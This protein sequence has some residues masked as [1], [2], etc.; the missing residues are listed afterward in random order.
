MVAFFD[1][2]QDWEDALSQTADFKAEGVDSPMMRDARV[3]AEAVVGFKNDQD[4]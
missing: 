1:A 3:L 2:C 4:R